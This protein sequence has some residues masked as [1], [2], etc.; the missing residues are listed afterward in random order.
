MK[1]Q[2]RYSEL[3]R[4]ASG[5][6]DPKKLIELVKEINRILMEERAATLRNNSSLSELD[7]A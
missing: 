1:D 4:Q 5:E 7:A 2:V 6:T 3:R